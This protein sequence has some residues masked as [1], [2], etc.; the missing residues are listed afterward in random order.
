MD[1]KDMIYEQQQVELE[2]TRREDLERKTEFGRELTFL[3]LL[4]GPSGHVNPAV[5]AGF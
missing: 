3:V 5:D 4:P 1:D 2:V